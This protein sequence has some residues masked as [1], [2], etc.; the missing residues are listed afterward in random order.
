MLANAYRTLANGG[1]WTPLRATPDAQQRGPLPGERL[2][3][4]LRRR[5]RQCCWQPP[6]ASWWATSS[7]TAP[8]APAPSASNPGW[9]RPTGPPPKPAPAR[10]CATTGV[11]A[12]RAATPSRSGSA[13]P[14]AAPMHD[15][16]GISGA[17]PVWREVMDW[18]HR[19]D[20][21]SHARAVN[22]ASP[23]PPPA[24]HRQ[25]S[26]SFRPAREPARDEWF[27]AGTETSIVRQASSGALAHI[28]YP[29]EGTHHCP[30]P[31]HST[32]TPTR[33][34][35][36]LRPRQHRLELA[37]R[38]QAT[39]PGALPLPPHLATPALAPTNSPWKTPAAR[40]STACA[41]KCAPCAAAA[42]RH[43]VLPADDAWPEEPHG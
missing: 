43:Q 31:R 24:G 30:R 17:A 15:V 29:A 36:P 22:R 41:S 6:A 20:P 23:P 14:A 40:K 8:R 10:T 3:R 11:P 42:K 28:S 34:P 18:L 5:P 12:T 25:P 7:P 4:R 39:R 37:Y 26:H 33:S 38:Q 16:S 21:A 9:R 2:R 19:G 1:R 13:M 27:I 35:P 32:A